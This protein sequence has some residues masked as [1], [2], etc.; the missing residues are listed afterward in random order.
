MMLTQIWAEQRYNTTV[1]CSKCEQQ[2]ASSSIDTDNQLR[3]RVLQKTI[4]DP[5]WTDSVMR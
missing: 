3:T 4:L 2:A 5:L 1:H